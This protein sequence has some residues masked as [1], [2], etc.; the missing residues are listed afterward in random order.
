MDKPPQCNGFPLR[1][2]CVQGARPRV[3]RHHG[4]H[5][6]HAVRHR[7]CFRRLQ[8]NSGGHFASANPETV[9]AQVP[10]AITGTLAVDGSN[11]NRRSERFFTAAILRSNVSTA[12]KRS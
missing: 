5:G 4:E 1:R 10:V 8:V 6:R 11:I 7:Q 12:R 2:F 3:G 9:G